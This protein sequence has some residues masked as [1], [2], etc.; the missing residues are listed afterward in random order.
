MKCAVELATDVD[1]S[2]DH[3]D[4]CLGIGTVDLDSFRKHSLVRF[5]ERNP[6][7]I[8]FSLW[9]HVYA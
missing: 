9:N 4:R 7:F 6:I 1:Q 2:V 8:T 3:L 5:L